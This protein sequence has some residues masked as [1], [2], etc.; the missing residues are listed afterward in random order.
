MEKVIFKTKK[1]I[2]LIVAQKFF[3]HFNSYF[4]IPK[5]NTIDLMFR[6]SQWWFVSAGFE[7]VDF[8]PPCF[9]FFVVLC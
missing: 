6:C 8:G 4:C 1:T 9:S 5:L 2:V 3:I 7:L